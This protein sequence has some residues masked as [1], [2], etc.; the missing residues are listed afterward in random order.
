MSCC[1]LVYKLDSDIIVPA[2]FGPAIHIINVSLYH[3]CENSAARR[4][5]VSAQTLS[6]RCC[7][8]RQAGRRT[9]AVLIFCYSFE[10][11]DTLAVKRPPR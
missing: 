2:S 9:L 6:E 8:E 7:G 10:K 3:L 1:E 4:N 11:R 5:V